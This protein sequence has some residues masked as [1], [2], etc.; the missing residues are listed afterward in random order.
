MNSEQDKWMFGWEEYTNRMTAGRAYAAEEGR[1]F[2]SWKLLMQGNHDNVTSECR[3][4]G[5]NNF[6]TQFLQKVGKNGS[7]EEI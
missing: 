2:K 4:Y 7:R 3:L 1:D 5:R 6:S